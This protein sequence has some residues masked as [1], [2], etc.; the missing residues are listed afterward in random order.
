MACNLMVYRGKPAASIDRIMSNSISTNRRDFLAG[1]SSD[2]NV[3]R[4]GEPA[5]LLRV[6]G[7][8]RKQQALWTGGF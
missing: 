3:H 5:L 6:T 4:Q 1:A 2:H 7:S 8:R